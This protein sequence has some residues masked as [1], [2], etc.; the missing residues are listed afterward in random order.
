[1]HDVARYD[2]EYRD[3]LMEKYNGGRNTR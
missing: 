1:V 2:P 3:S